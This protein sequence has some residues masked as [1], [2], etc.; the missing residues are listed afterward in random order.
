VGAGLFLD[1]ARR[2]GYAHDGPTP[3]IPVAGII[4]LPRPEADDLGPVYAE[5]RRRLVP[6]LRVVE[7]VAVGFESAVQAMSRMATKR[8]TNPRTLRLLN[9]YVATVECLAA[10]W[11]IPCYE[12]AATTIKKFLTGDG[13]ADKDA[14][15]KMCRLLGWEFG[16]DDNAADACAGWAHLRS[17]LE[18]GWAPRTTPLFARR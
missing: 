7:P 16:D 4:L 13:H 8:E 2:C 6:I 18:P 14:M 10:E 12:T 3:G 5:L 9:G 15:M 1:L 11:H 17:L